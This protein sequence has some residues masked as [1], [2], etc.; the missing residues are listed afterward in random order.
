MVFELLLK[1]VLGWLCLGENQK[2][3]SVTIETMNNKEFFGR[4]L[5][6]NIL[7]QHGIERLRSFPLCGDGKQTTG[8]LYHNQL[9]I[10]KQHFDA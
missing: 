9:V 6:L 3:G 7:E 10:L 1:V 8:F 5:T 4:P 2:S